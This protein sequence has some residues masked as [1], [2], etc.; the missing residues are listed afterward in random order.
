MRWY[1]ICLE[2]GS[3]AIN[4]YDSK[5]NA[6]KKAAVHLRQKRECTIVHGTQFQLIEKQAH[7]LVEVA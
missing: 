5:E 1:V 7:I 6:E 4:V 3:S 2:Y